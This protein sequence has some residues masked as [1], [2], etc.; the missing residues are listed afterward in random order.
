MHVLLKYS[1]VF[2]GLAAIVGLGYFIK[3]KYFSKTE[4]PPSLTKEE[5]IASC[6][7]KCQ[8]FGD[9][10]NEGCKKIGGAEEYACK[11]GC[12]ATNMICNSTCT[13][14]SGLRNASVHHINVYD[15][16]K[17]WLTRLTPI[18]PRNLP[19]EPTDFPIY[20]TRCPELD[21]VCPM[22]DQKFVLKID[23][24]G[25]Y[26]LWGGGPMELYTTTGACL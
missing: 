5:L 2:L 9:I 4:A 15:K 8:L 20:A 16:N 23:D 21:E 1:L 10:C 17:K 11:L 13:G 6:K 19:L 25:C 14:K 18:E 3:L 22:N 26:I 12:K 24:P 7:E